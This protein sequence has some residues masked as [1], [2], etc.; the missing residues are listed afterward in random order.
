MLCQTHYPFYSSFSRIII[1]SSSKVI[2]FKTHSMIGNITGQNYALFYFVFESITVRNQIYITVLF[3]NIMDKL[4]SQVF[5][6]L[7][8]DFFS[9]LENDYI[10]EFVGV[11]FIKKEF[12]HQK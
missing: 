3:A 11:A 1:Q 7:F 6:K 12:N 4:E 8:C 2:V 9:T 10:F 5:N